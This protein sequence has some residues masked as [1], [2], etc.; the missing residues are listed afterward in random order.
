MIRHV[1]ALASLSI[2]AL[3]APV[4]SA[5]QVVN[6]EFQDTLVSSSGSET[7]TDLGT[8]SYVDDTV[9]GQPCRVFSFAAQTGLSLDMTGLLGGSAYTFVTTMR[10]SDVQSYA[11]V[12]DLHDLGSDYGLYAVYG[13][14]RF[15]WYGYDSTET[16]A[17]DTWATIA[18]AFDGTRLRGYVD[19]VETFSVVDSDDLGQIT[20]S[21]LYFFRDDD[22]TGGES[23][24]GRVANIQLFDTALTAEEIGDLD[25]YCNRNAA[26]PT[27]LTEDSYDS[28]SAVG[29]FTVDGGIGWDGN[30]AG[31]GMSGSPGLTGTGQFLAEPNYTRRLELSSPELD[32]L[33][34]DPVADRVLGGPGV[35]IWTSFWMQTDD[36]T[37][38]SFNAIVGF[39][40]ADF[41]T[42]FENGFSDNQLVINGGSG[43]G[44]TLAGSDLTTATFI[45]ARWSYVGDQSGQIDIWLNPTATTEAD[46]GPPTGSTPGAPGYIESFDRV[47]FFGSNFEIDELRIGTTYVAVNPGIFSDDF[48]SGDTLRW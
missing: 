12:L 23:S 29:A 45:V 10:L 34:V 40:S 18:L 1:L 33:L 37:Q 26:T 5:E 36:A 13:T 2:S 35:E 15:Y 9:F 21:T 30:V 48:E 32:P 11:K 17:A 38:G 46:L 14:A 41:D 47:S 44:V 4:A 7:L 42:T 39:A 22:G 19:G 25:F 6:F 20:A 27:L 43:N 3:V 8:N 24:S 31:S 16:L 28:Y